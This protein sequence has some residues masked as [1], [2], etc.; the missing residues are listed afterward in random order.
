MKYAGMAELADAPDLGSGGQPCRFD[1]CYPHQSARW[2][3]KAAVLFYF[4]KKR[5][6]SAKIVFYGEE[7]KYTHHC[8][9]INKKPR[10]HKGDL[11]I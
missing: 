7:L 3:V 5:F 8:N 10:I 6:I 1:S 9:I 2:F 11:A 4:Y